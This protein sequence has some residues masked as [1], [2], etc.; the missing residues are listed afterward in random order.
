MHEPVGVALRSPSVATAGVLRDVGV[1]VR[2]G[3]FS[4]LSWRS[5]YREVGLLAF[6]T[7]SGY[8]QTL[9]SLGSAVLNF[10]FNELGAREL[11]C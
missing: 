3:G 11:T 8:T 10:L 2:I 6:K 1:P 5:D 9:P 4:L 7:P